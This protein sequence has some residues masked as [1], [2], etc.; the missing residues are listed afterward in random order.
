MNVAKIAS[1]FNDRALSVGDSKAGKSFK[2]WGTLAAL[3]LAAMPTINSH[4]ESRDR[5]AEARALHELQMQVLSNQVAVAAHNS[6]LEVTTGK[7]YVE[8]AMATAQ[9]ANEVNRKEKQK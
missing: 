8:R 3:I 2:L 1:T 4:V 9:R 5:I 6:I 7:P